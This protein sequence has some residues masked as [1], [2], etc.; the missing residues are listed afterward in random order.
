[1]CLRILPA[2]KPDLRQMQVALLPLALE[3]FV[4]VRGLAQ[5]AAQWLRQ[6]NQWKPPK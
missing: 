5:F 2:Q 3:G 6:A 1:M 4:T